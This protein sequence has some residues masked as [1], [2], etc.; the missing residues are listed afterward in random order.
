M[1]KRNESFNCMRVKKCL[2]FLW[3][4]V[5]YEINSTQLSTQPE[6]TDAGVNTSMFAS[7]CSYFL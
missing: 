5:R 3:K 4:L 2:S 7:L 6:I 1:L